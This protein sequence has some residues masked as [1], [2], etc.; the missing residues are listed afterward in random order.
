MKISVPDISK[1]IAITIYARRYSLFW[2]IAAMVIIIIGWFPY[3]LSFNQMPVTF[4]DDWTWVFMMHEGARKSIVEYQQFPF[5]IPWHKGGV[6]LFAHPLV[7]VF[8]FDTLF[9]L[10]LGTVPGLRLAVMFDVLFG[11]L[12]MWLLLKRVEKINLF[13]F[14][15]TVLFGLQGCIAMH[16]TAGHIC[17]LGIIWLPWLALFALAAPRRLSAAIALGFFAGA[18]MLQFFHYLSIINSLV[19]MVLLL[20]I[21]KKEFKNI[22]FYQNMIAALLTF[23]S[24]ASFRL[25]ITIPLCM[26]YTNNPLP[27]LISISPWLF[28]KALVWPMQWI[29]TMP[30]AWKDVLRWHELGCYIGIIAVLMFFCSL[31]K[32]WRWFHTAFILAVLLTLDASSPWRPGYWVNGQHVL[33]VPTR[34]RFVVVFILIFGAVAGIKALTGKFRNRNARKIFAGCLVFISVAGLI[35]SQHYNW[36]HRKMVSLDQVNNLFRNTG[37]PIFMAKQQDSYLYSAIYRNIGLKDSFDPLYKAHGMRWV[38][39]F[40]DPEYRD[41]ISAVPANINVR[42]WSPNQIIISTTT[43]VLIAINQNASR[44]WRL[45]GA[46]LFPDS[47]YV[48]FSRQFIFKTLGRQ[49]LIISAIPS[50]YEL[51]LTVTAISVA[52]L[53]GYLYCLLKIRKAENKKR[54]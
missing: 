13:C 27:G 50:H 52:L 19:I 25:I 32:G 3:I 4:D 20:W 28:L 42:K 11:A 6:P 41:E 18:M 2:L 34:W 35:F 53:G 22:S 37:K 43:P 46:L 14:W 48:D 15:G 10:L 45:N 33:R 5:W 44:Y 31:I 47:T 36:R 7:S 51:G 21:W 1:K 29:H 49:T 9:V 23:L 39:A 26:Q 40:N 38:K 54:R 8:S 24:I 16:V 12:G 30:H 17:M